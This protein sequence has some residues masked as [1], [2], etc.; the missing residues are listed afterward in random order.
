MD[1]RA[2]VKP[3]WFPLEWNLHH[4]FFFFLETQVALELTVFH[5]PDSVSHDWDH[6]LKLLCPSLFFFFCIYK[7]SKSQKDLEFKILRSKAFPTGDS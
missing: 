7:S 2:H 4:A 5:H 6:R 3:F 1:G